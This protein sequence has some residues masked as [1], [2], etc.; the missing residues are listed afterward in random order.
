MVFYTIGGQ[1]NETDYTKEIDPGPL[2]IGFDYHFGVPQ[3]HGDATGIYLRNRNTVGLRT[4]HRR[5]HH[6]QQLGHQLITSST[7]VV[8]EL[9]KSI[10]KIITT[11]TTIASLGVSTIGTCR[12]PLCPRP[13]VS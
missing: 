4:W 9:T 3:N 5:Q 8:V 1:T 2:D 13:P 11:A 7:L 12:V 10:A 6:H